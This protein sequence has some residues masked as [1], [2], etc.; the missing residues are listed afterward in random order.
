MSEV[1]DDGIRNEIR[2]LVAEA[3]TDELE[4]PNLQN[5]NDNEQMFNNQNTVDIEQSDELQLDDNPEG[6]EGY[7][8]RDRNEITHPKKF[9]DYEIYHSYVEE[10]IPTYEKC[11]SD[12]LWKTAIE[13]EK[14]ALMKNNVWELTDYETAKGKEILSSRWI[15]KIKEDGRYKA[16]LVVRGCQ[17]RGEIDYQER[18][19]PVVDTTNLRMMFAIAANNKMHIKTFDVK[20]AFLN[21]TLE[22]DIYMKVPE[23][24]EGKNKVC[25]LKK[26]LYGLKQ[27]PLRWFKRLT[28]FLKQEN[29][30]QLKSDRCIFKTEDNSIVMAIHVDDGIIM[31][32][33]LEQISLL[34]TKLKETFEVIVNDNPK[35][36][37]LECRESTEEVPNVRLSNSDD[38]TRSTSEK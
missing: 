33:D 16:R 17:Q 23:G 38:T 22:Q 9:D 19:S 3:S 27:A 30:I 8:L 7:W 5:E 36:Y 13:E 26:A 20:T 14:R 29:I 15:L 25:R 31:G 32:K 1:T 18:Y 12:P 24:F 4:N 21:G 6:N 37:I 35:T 11:H 34:I 28:T 2:D 10:E